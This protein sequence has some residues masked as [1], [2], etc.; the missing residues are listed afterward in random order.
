MSTYEAWLEAELAFS[1]RALIG[2][3]DEIEHV[4]KG[5]RARIEADSWLNA[6]GELQQ[7]GPMLDAAV[8]AY[9]TQRQAL[10]NFRE[11]EE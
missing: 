7:Q 9:A 2:R 5:L 10:K 4:M 1:R 6:L 11:M 3:I 8:A